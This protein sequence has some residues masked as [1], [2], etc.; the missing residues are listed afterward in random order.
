MNRSLC[1]KH[2]YP[3][4]EPM[5]DYLVADD[6]TGER[7]IKWNLDKPQP[8][9]EQL[10]AVWA[11]AFGAAQIGQLNEHGK[12]VMLAY[13]PEHHQANAALRIYTGSK[14]D[15]VIKKIKTGRSIIK[16]KEQQIQD[17]VLFG[18]ISGIKQVTVSYESLKDEIGAAMGKITDAV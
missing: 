5:R 13:V 7:I 18:D 17:A 1:I 6:G 16:E 12:A 14:R 9:D 10:M 3:F 4:A 15:N 8:T 11:A 2:L